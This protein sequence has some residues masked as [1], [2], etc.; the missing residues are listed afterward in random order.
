[1]VELDGN[2]CI[3]KDLTGLV[4]WLD[5][6]RPNI[7]KVLGRLHHPDESGGGEIP[8]AAEDLVLFRLIGSALQVMSVC[9]RTRGLLEAQEF[10]YEGLL[11]KLD[12]NLALHH[13][14]KTRHIRHRQS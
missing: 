11:G 3:E 13:L 7:I 14:C 10:R 2:G 1:V 8:M 9:M 5:D 6:A 4:V 12:L